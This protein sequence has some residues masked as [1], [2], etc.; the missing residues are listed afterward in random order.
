[1][2]SISSTTPSL[3]SIWSILLPSILYSL[4]WFLVKSFKEKPPRRC[5]NSFLRGVTSEIGL[6]Y[7]WNIVLLL[8]FIPGG[9]FGLLIGLGIETPFLVYWH[10]QGGAAFIVIALIHLLDHMTYFLKGWKVLGIK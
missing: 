10:Y 3:I 7:I 4:H 2:I 8:L 1:M 5:E 9:L 6:K